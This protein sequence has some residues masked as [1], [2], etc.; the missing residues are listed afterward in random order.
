MMFSKA[1]VRQLSR[2]TTSTTTRFTAA[3]SFGASANVEE[4]FQEYGKHVFSGAVAD[5]YLKMHGA[6]VALLKDPTWVQHSSDTV[7]A[8]VFDWYVTYG[9]RRWNDAFR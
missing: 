8:A 9:R 5:E 1:A 6:S 4:S 7:A 3:R 2:F